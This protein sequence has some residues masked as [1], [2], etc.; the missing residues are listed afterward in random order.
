MKGKNSGSSLTYEC[1][2]KWYDSLFQ[3]LGWMVVDFER[4]YNVDA[5]KQEVKELKSSISDKMKGVRDADKKAD[6][7]IMLE[8]TKIL[9]NHIDKDFGGNA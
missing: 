5:Y 2:H 1:L 6:L 9:L 4:G 3:K 7:K 8:N